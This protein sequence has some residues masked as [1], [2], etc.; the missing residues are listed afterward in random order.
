MREKR[1]SRCYPVFTFWGAPILF[2]E[3]SFCMASCSYILYIYIYIYSIL[4][5]SIKISKDL[6]MSEKA[7]KQLVTSQ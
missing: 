6:G 1:R 2:S 7:Q 3:I 5:I 4:K